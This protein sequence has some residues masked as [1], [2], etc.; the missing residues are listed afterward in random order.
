MRGV[1][2]SR[3]GLIASGVIGLILTYFLAARAVYTGSYWQYLG[4]LILLVLSV[5]LLVKAFNNG[6]K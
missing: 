5:K 4:T 1:L 6:N 3:N 2:Q